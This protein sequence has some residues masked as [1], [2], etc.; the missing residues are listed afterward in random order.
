MLAAL[1][2]VTLVVGRSAICHVNFRTFCFLVGS[3]LDLAGSAL[4][5][6]AIWISHFDI[7][8]AN[9][10]F[11]FRASQAFGS[12]RPEFLCVLFVGRVFC[13]HYV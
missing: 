5:I 9:I 4:H 12:I 1:L 8:S 6:L 11:E 10:C 13:V 7:P 2:S 3:L